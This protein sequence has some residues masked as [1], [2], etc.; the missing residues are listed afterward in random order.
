MKGYEEYVQPPSYVDVQCP[1]GDQLIAKLRLRI[2]Q[3]LNQINGVYDIQISES[4]QTMRSHI[5]KLEDIHQDN[6]VHINNQRAKDI[7]AYNIEAERKIDNL[8]ST[9][10][11]SPQKNVQSWWGT[12]FGT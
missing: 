5:K 10:H 12:V 3:D 7:A 9:M 2:Q 1:E 4:E 6:V 8:I 11:N